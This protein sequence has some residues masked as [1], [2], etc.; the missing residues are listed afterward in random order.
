MSGLWS[1]V[2][3]G[4]SAAGYA[5]GEHYGKSALMDQE[6]AL[7][8]NRA[9]RLAE[10]QADLELRGIKPKAQATADATL[11]A[12]PTLAEASSITAKGKANDELAN[13]PTKRKA[14][15]ESE[16]SPEI[17][18]AKARQAEAETA[19]RGRAETKTLTDRGNDPAHIR[20][21][22]NLAQAKHI[23]GLGSVK[24][25]TL[26]QMAIDEKVKVNAMI[27]EF[28]TTK[29]PQRKAEI[30]EALTVR[31]IIKS[32][33]YDTEKVTEEKMNDDGTTTK[34]ERTQRRRAGVPAD[35]AKKPKLVIGQEVD[36]YVYQGGDPKDQSN[37]VSKG[38]M[39]GGNVK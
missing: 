33:E 21:T 2:G 14:L 24:Q 3:R 5:A 28:T 37:W 16:Y 35:T 36:G 13:A 1:A 23:E 38:R 22:R 32:S 31:G 4:L 8:E 18:D 6:S 7:V 39:S 10:F 29:D 9:K 27:E 25:A 20:A 15:M 26:A 30:K 34:T 19:A 17:T 12:A 11:A